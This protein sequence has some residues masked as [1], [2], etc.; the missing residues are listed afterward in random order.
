M[1]VYYV[2]Y[3][4]SLWIRY[5]CDFS[6]SLLTLIIVLHQRYA[7]TAHIQKNQNQNFLSSSFKNILQTWFQKHKLQ[8]SRL[9]K[10]KTS[11]VCKCWWIFWNIIKT[12]CIVCSQQIILA[13]TAVEEKMTQNFVWTLGEQTQKKHKKKNNSPAPQ[14]NWIELRLYLIFQLSLLFALIRKLSNRMFETKQNEK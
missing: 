2:L 3:S 11:C 4:L 10:R 13:V 12:A 8:H 7:C 6:F 9:Q 1:F 14:N 5:Y